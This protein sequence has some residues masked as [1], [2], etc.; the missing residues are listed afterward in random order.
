MTAPGVGRDGLDDQGHRSVPSGTRRLTGMSPT[1]PPA[2]RDHLRAVPLTKATAN[3]FV[4]E[5]YRHHPP[6]LQARFCVG[7]A[8]AGVLVGVA[9]VE[10]PENCQLANG[11]RCEVSRLCTDGSPQ[12]CSFLYS[13]SARIARE[14]GYAEIITYILDREPGTSLRAAGWT[15]DPGTYG[16]QTWVREKR[17]TRRDAPETLTPRQRWR[18]VLGAPVGA[19]A[20]ERAVLPVALA[21][22][23]L[24]T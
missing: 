16:G 19:R 20:I 23:R 13:R 18:R 14:M 3:V 8:R 6:V 10:N 5:R 17:P 2:P 15:R 22:P 24:F 12:V 11:D 4:T 21:P 7:A 1:T 9:I